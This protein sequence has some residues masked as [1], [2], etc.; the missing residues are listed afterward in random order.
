MLS[1]RSRSCQSACSTA[2]C[3]EK[4]RPRP[5]GSPRRNIGILLSQAQ[6]VRQYE[7]YNQSRDLDRP[8]QVLLG[9]ILDTI[10]DPGQAEPVE[11]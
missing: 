7:R 1:N 9:S 8:T 5:F 6:I 10:E 2:E 4:R 3:R 11:R